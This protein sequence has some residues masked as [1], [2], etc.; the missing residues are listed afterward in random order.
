MIAVNL[1]F[2]LFFVDST[3]KV[4]LDF[5]ASSDVF[6]AFSFELINYVVCPLYLLQ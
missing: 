4:C 1:L 3:S 6:D 2:F 5:R